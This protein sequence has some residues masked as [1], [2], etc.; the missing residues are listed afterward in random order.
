MYRF[1]RLVA[2]VY[3]RRTLAGGGWGNQKTDQGFYKVMVAPPEIPRNAQQGKV[4]AA[5]RMGS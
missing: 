1:G 4:K 5:P 3:I 2:L